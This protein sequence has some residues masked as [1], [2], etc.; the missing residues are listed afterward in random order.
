MN[1]VAHLAQIT[2]ALAEL[3]LPHLVMGGQAVRYD[4]FNR[5]TTDHDLHLAAGSGG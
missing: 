4:G 2:A 1:V 5:E 3:H